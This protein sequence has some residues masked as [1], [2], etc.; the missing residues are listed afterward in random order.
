MGQALPQ[1][2]LFLIPA[3]GEPSRDSCTY[4]TCHTA[5]NKCRSISLRSHI[6]TLVSQK[7]AGPLLQG[8][9]LGPTL[10][11][12]ASEHTENGDRSQK[13]PQRQRPHSQIKVSNQ[14]APAGCWDSLL[15]LSCM[16]AAE[17][18]GL[19]HFPCTVSPGN[20]HRNFFCFYTNRDFFSCP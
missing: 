1:S 18:A 10:L 13:S 14:S 6:R 17:K 11:P 8:P 5:L 4:S 20:S 2:C 16:E 15:A 19:L 9:Q 3:S 7:G 12:R